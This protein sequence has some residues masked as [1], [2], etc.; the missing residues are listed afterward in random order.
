MAGV[1][2]LLLILKKYVQPDTIAESG[3]APFLKSEP[4]PIYPLYGWREEDGLS[5]YGFI[6]EDLY[7]ED[8][9]LLTKF[10]EEYGHCSVFTFD[11]VRVAEGSKKMRE[12]TVEE[13]LKKGSARINT[14]QRS[15]PK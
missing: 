11:Q 15:R 12:Q 8:L 9:E 13:V 4:L 3:L 2:R 7:L 6:L 14:L 5:H 1:K 10:V